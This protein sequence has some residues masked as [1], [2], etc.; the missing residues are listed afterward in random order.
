[1]TEW[2]GVGQPGDEPGDLLDDEGMPP[3]DNVS[4]QPY[5]AILA[6]KGG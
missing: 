5:P 6:T 1:M 3:Y 2:G 4:A